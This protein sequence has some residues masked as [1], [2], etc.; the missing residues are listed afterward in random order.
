MGAHVWWP[1]VPARPPV[2]VAP[3]GL[4]ARLLRRVPGRSV[5]LPGS[6]ADDHRARRRGPVQR[7]VQADHRAR[8]DP[9]PDRRVRVRR[10][11]RAPKPTPAAFAVASTSLLFFTGDP[12]TSSAATTIAFNQRIMGGTLAST[13]AGE[14]S[15][16]IALAFALLFFGTFAICAPQSA[17]PV[18]ARDA[19]GRV[20]D[21][22]PGRRDL[23][24]VRRVRGLAVP[25]SARE[26]DARRWRSVPSV[27]C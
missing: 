7:R 6:G 10:G 1:R 16:T 5:L 20:P 21:E 22:P 14:Y 4:V 23:R 24:R 8:P 19:P 18:A 26:R 27:C 2:A 25:G 15:F 3:R 9:P 12:G 17:A 13:L 11:L